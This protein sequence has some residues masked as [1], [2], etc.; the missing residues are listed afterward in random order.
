MRTVIIMGAPC[1]ELFPRA[2]TL[3][4]QFFFLNLLILDVGF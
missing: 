1:I 2:G 3:T 4:Y